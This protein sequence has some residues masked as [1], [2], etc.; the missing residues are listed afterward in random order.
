MLQRTTEEE[1]WRLGLESALFAVWDLDPRAELV[2][3]SPQWK[4]AFGFGNADAPD[5]TSF[6]RSRVH[7]DDLAPMLSALQA[8]LDGFS[9]A[10]EMQFRLRNGAGHYRAVLSRGRVVERNARG[11]AVRMVGTMT[12]LARP[13]PALPAADAE[14]S[15]LLS[16]ELRTP[17]HAILGFSQLLSRSLAPVASDDQRRQLALI[18]QAGWRLLSLVDDLLERAVRDTKDESR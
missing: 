13:Q 5:S 1:R 4:A 18:E 16:H 17:L 11:D 3:Y 14:R 2:H 10:Y 8:H 12:E 7:P 9:P 15:S 6:W